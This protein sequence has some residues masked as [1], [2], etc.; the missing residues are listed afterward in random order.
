MITFR[1]PAKI[2]RDSSCGTRITVVF[3]GICDFVGRNGA[4]FRKS[5]DRAEKLLLTILFT[6]VTL[7]HAGVGQRWDKTDGN[8]AGESIRRQPKRKFHSQNRKNP[9]WHVK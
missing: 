2:A 1:V 3:E 4:F 7:S 8:L 5:W 6:I 9:L